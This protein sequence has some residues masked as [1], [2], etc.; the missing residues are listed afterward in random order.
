MSL[1]TTILLTGALGAVLGFMPA[2]Q[3]QDVSGNSQAQQANMQPGIRY[4]TGSVTTAGWEKGLTDGDPNLKRW[5]WSSMTS[6][7]Q[8]CYNRVPAG[9]FLKKNKPDEVQALRPP[10]SIYTNPIKVNPETY[11]KKHIQPGVIVVGDTSN[12]SNVSGRVRLPRQ[13]A[14]LAPV[15]K[16][17]NV[18][19]GVG[20]TV[21]L[22]H[23][24]ESLASRQ[25]FGRLMKTQ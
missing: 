11:A 20:G 9:A 19:Y 3:A 25:V 6:Y 23:E 17:Y 16:S 2:A 1:K 7:T 12:K 13:V 21:R 24:T 4:T 8:S 14:E 15:A 18:N 5:N 22:P 10:G